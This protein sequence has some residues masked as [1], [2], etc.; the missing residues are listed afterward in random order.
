LLSST[1]ATKDVRTRVRDFI[2]QSP[3]LFIFLSCLF[4]NNIL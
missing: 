2:L 3:V 1:S 4:N